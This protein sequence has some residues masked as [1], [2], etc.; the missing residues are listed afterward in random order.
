MNEMIYLSF[1]FALFFILLRGEEGEVT[2]RDLV[3]RSLRLTAGVGI[4]VLVDSQF[5]RS[6]WEPL[7]RSDLRF[8]SL[9]FWALVIDEAL[10]R[11]RGRREKRT[12]RLL[13]PPTSLA[14]FG[15]AL[16]AIGKTKL[17]LA[18]PLA[19]GLVEWLLLGLKERIRLS[20]LPRALEGTPILFWL[21]AL[22]ALSFGWIRLF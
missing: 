1:G 12:V 16:A 9:L 14:L 22:L 3:I 15:F 11:I 6:L 2:P 5:S 4:L 17:T 8:L 13:V 10:N 18:L 7:G 20:N 21:A 19:S